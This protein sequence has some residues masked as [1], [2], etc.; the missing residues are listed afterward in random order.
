MESKSKKKV[1]L[2]A[3]ALCRPF[4]DQ[5]NIRIRLETDAVYMILSKIHAQEL[6]A[7]KSPV[8]ELELSAIKSQLEKKEVMALLSKFSKGDGL[9]V[10]SIRSRADELH[11]LGF[12]VA[13]AAHLAYAEYTADVFI[14]CDDK[15]LKKSQIEKVHVSTYNPA[16]FVIK[17]DL[18][19]NK[20][21]LKMNT[22]TFLS[23]EELIEKVANILIESLGEVE[24]T[25][26]FAIPQQKREESVSRHRKWQDSLDKE[27]FFDEVFPSNT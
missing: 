16:D 15:L 11:Q 14:T 21:G 13:D 18:I 20:R 9:D 6:Y 19:C 5:Q 22:S 4:D 8:H 17:E 27:H 25:R 1:Y 12:G 23:E 24:A 3:C 7:I 26:F 10:K 2:D